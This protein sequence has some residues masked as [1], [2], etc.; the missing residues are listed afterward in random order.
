MILL[1]NRLFDNPLWSDRL[2]ILLIGITHTKQRKALIQDS[3]DI[4][5]AKICKSVNKPRATVQ[6]RIKKLTES[7]I[8]EHIGSARNGNWV[9]K[10]F[11]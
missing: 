10:N 11:I 6:R 1:N 9:I 4:T 5:Q 3:P 2:F 8:V 7:G